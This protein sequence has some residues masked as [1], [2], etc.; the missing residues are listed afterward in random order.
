[1]FPLAS[2]QCA[3]LPEPWCRFQKH[4]VVVDDARSDKPKVSWA[5]HYY[6]CGPIHDFNSWIAASAPALLTKPLLVS[7]RLRRIEVSVQQHFM[8]PKVRLRQSVKINGRISQNID[9]VLDSGL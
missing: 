1:M 5:V 8:D 3:L 2:I 7:R 6:Y 4:V 9:F